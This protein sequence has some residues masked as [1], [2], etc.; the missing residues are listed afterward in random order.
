M[1]IEAL[2]ADQTDALQ[3]VV[4]IAMGQA[5]D[6][7]A[8]TLNVF[9]ELSVP[10]I[11][12]VHVS[13]V[14]RTVREMIPNTSLVSAVR[15]AFFDALRGEAVVIYAVAGCKDLAILMGYDDK[16]SALEEQ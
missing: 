14:M 10:R 13:E 6:R 7:L 16:L 11:R 9:V 4:N 2:N 12:L 3:E 15:Q 1:T 8:R 5:G